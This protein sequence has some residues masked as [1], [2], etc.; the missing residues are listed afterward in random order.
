MKRFFIILFVAV[1]SLSACSKEMAAPSA[2]SETI[3]ATPAPSPSPE[4]LLTHLTPE[5]REQKALEEGNRWLEENYTSWG[6]FYAH[7]EDYEYF[8]SLPQGEPAV[9]TIQYFSKKGEAGQKI[10]ELECQYIPVCEELEQIEE[11]AEKGLQ[12][13]G[14]TYGAD[15]SAWEYDNPYIEKSSLPLEYFQL[16]EQAREI[17]LQITDELQEQRDE[18][19]N[20]LALE[21][22][23]LLADQDCKTEVWAVKNTENYQEKLYYVC[24]LTVT[25]EQLWELGELTEISSI[26][27][28][29]QYETVRLRHDIPIWS[30]EAAA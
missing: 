10:N 6:K 18:E 16:K 15:T 29:P 28:E 12:I 11:A 3:S 27:I 2:A 25:P 30:S 24:F 8:Q 13:Q 17:A 22:A 26:F 5:E 14:Y 9:F 4:A 23:Q 1:L 20:Q 21:L 7:N 19:R